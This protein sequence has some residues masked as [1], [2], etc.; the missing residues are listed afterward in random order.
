MQCACKQQEAEHALQKRIGEIQL[1]E[2]AGHRVVQRDAGDDGV[3]HHQPD[4]AQRAHHGQADDVRQLQEVMIEP[5]QQGRGD[6]QD[7]RHVEGGKRCGGS[8]MHAI[9]LTSD[10]GE[11]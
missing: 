9:R 3:R 8:L 10:G 5:A 7:R 2:Q 4:C 11:G 1:L 6:H